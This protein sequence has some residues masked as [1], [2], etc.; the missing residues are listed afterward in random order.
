MWNR[1]DGYQFLTTQ[2]EDTWKGHIAM[3]AAAESVWLPQ[4]N[5]HG[6]LRECKS[7]EWQSKLGLLYH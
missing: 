2:C 1:L 6:I 5:L 3:Q 4:P 7:T